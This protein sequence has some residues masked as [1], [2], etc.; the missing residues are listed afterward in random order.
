MPEMA[1][2]R[3]PIAHESAI[4]DPDPFVSLSP[5]SFWM[6]S[7]Q[8]VVFSKMSAGFS[9]PV[10]LEYRPSFR[11]CL[12][13]ITPGLSIVIFLEVKEVQLGQPWRLHVDEM[14]VSTGG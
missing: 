12:V 9:S 11:A 7:N 5:M 6:V 3:C 1:L 14:I 2:E 13:K 4:D 10:G 8:P